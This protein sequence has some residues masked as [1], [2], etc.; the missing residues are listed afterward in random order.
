MSVKKFI[1]KKS[2]LEEGATI[3]E[4]AEGIFGKSGIND[5]VRTNIRVM[6]EFHFLKKDSD[7]FISYF[8]FSLSYI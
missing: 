7:I 6:E 5:T 4:I 3:G 8:W 2:L 1:E